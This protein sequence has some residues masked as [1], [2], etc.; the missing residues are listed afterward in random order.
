MVYSGRRWLGQSNMVFNVKDMLDAQAYI[1][2]AGTFSDIRLFTPN[3]EWVKS[4]P[5]SVTTFSA[6]CYTAALSMRSITE[7]DQ[8]HGTKLRYRPFGLMMVAV[9]GSHIEAWCSPDALASCNDSTDNSTSS[10]GGGDHNA[11]LF[12]SQVWTT[13]T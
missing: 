7:L 1:D 6:V 5:I 9:S 10:C 12:R 11:V 3:K 2:D 13:A 8:L 4:S